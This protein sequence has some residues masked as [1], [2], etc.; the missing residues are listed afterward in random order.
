MVTSK[1]IQKRGR[2]FLTKFLFVDI[3]LKVG[4]KILIICPEGNKYV[5]IGILRFTISNERNNR[6]ISN[7]VMQ[8]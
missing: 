4:L 3:M 2:I 5:N 1:V 7:K 8:L 6:E